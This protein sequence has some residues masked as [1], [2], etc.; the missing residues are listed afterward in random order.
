[1]SFVN[2]SIEY[3]GALANLRTKKRLLDE[4]LLAT[5]QDLGTQL[6]TMVQ[7]NLSGEVLESRTGVLLSAVAQQAAEFVEAVCQTSV[8]IDDDDPSWIVGMTHEYGG[9]DWY[10]IYPINGKALAFL[11]EAGE[12]TFA[13]HVH[14]PPAQE[15]SWLRSALDD[16][17]ADAVDQ[18]KTTIAG[19]LAA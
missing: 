5:I 14:H 8:G 3:E 13:R 12:T 2:L 15:R 1:M 11:G 16:I 10:D 18:I 17:E 7:G 19:V 9:N 6:L 4:A